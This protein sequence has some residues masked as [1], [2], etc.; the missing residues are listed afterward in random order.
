MQVVLEGGEN[1]ALRCT[2][3]SGAGLRPP[4]GEEWHNVWQTPA[5]GSILCQLQVS[6]HLILRQTRFYAVIP[7]W[8]KGKTGSGQEPPT[9]SRDER[10]EPQG[11][12]GVWSGFGLCTCLHLSIRENVSGHAV[13]ECL[14]YFCIPVTRSPPFYSP[15]EN[16]CFFATLLSRYPHPNRL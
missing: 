15:G 8:H 4:W 3:V 12:L 7:D 5:K 14:N 9:H 13:A 10:R 16:S 2:P 1:K 11:H 6:T